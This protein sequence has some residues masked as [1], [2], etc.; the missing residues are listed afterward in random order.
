MAT[1]L[2]DPRAI[3]APRPAAV[4]PYKID[5]SRGERIGRVSSEWFKRTQLPA[6][7]PPADRERELV[8]DP[9]CQVDQA[10]AHH[11]MH[12]RDRAGLHHPRQGTALIGVE[13]RAATRRLAV[14]EPGR[15]LGIEPDDPVAHDLERDTTDPRRRPGFRPRR[16]PPPPGAAAPASRRDLPV[17]ASATPPRH[18][19]TATSPPPPSRTSR[20]SRS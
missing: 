10:P 3:S 9:L 11:I 17:P 2:S 16:S 4:G 8:P 15:P 20:R 14:D 19:P 5:I 18:S 7:S 12:G 13:H 1:I 6:Q